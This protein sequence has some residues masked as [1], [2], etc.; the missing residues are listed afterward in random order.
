MLLLC[1]ISYDYSKPV[2]G[3]CSSA[4]AITNSLVLGLLALQTY[5]PA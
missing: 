1:L 5:T 4:A 3:T 2:P